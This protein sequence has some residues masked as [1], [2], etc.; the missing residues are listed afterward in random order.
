M[1]ACVRLCVCLT[2]FVS[3]FSSG[4]DS[5]PQHLDVFAAGAAVELVDPMVSPTHGVS[6]L[7]LVLHMHT[8]VDSIHTKYLLRAHVHTHTHREGKRESQGVMNRLE[9]LHVLPM[10]NFSY[11]HSL[12]CMHTLTCNGLH[13]TSNI[14]IHLEKVETD[15]FRNM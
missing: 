11:N 12:S 10:Y 9:K 14:W 5:A 8:E 7:C 1:F 13:I 4:A 3:I 15:E 2:I 6:H